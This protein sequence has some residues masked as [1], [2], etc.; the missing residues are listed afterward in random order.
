MTNIE[1]LQEDCD[2]WQCL[3]LRLARHIRNTD[4]LPL[5]TWGTKGVDLLNEVRQMDPATYDSYVKPAGAPPIANPEPQWTNELPKESGWYWT[6]AGKPPLPALVTIAEDGSVYLDNDDITLLFVPHPE[7]FWMK[8][9]APKT[10]EEPKNPALCSVPDK[11][12]PSF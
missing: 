5:C 12:A 3:A 7:R 2:K 10:G 1:G 11:R 4:D 6:H 8:L 9:E